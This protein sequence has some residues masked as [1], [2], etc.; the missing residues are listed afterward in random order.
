MPT[1]FDGYADD[2]GELLDDPIRR[3]FAGKQEFFHLR[4]LKVFRRF[5]A[6]RG[7]AA[8]TVSW[9]DIGCGR[10]DLLRLGGGDFGG[11]YGCDVS[12]DMLK[13]CGGLDV[14][15]QETPGRLPFPDH[16]ANFATAVCVYHHIDLGR[17]KAFTEEAVRILKPGGIFCIIEHN[18]FNLLTQIIVRNT[19]VDARAHLLTSGASWRLLTGQNM[20]ILDQQY[21]LWLPEP[22]YRRF[23]FLEDCLSG[24]P[25]GGQYAVFGEKPTLSDHGLQ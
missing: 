15:L 21:F 16:F 17:R 25:L 2:Y 3:A 20:R 14:R 1:E 13:Y 19:P 5:L 24:V 23:S 10:G 18:P 12:R 4:K 9:V 6:R 11:A 22:L 7:V 8:K